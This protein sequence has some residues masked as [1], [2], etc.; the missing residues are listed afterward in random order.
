MAI[1]GIAL[2]LTIAGVYGVLSYV[3]A[4]RTREIG[5]RLALGAS[6]GGVARVVVAQSLA[7]AAIGI[8]IGT[9][10]A[11][12]ASKAL[13]SRIHLIDPFDV[14]GYAIGILVIL[15]AAVAASFVPARRASRVNPLEAL[16]A[17]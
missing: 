14:R 11:L 10:L 13:L 4:Q 6:I 12:G 5:I 8:L 17:E 7:F 15:T 3:V 1:G 16:R 2:L 9:S